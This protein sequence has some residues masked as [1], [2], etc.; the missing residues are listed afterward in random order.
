MVKLGHEGMGHEKV[1]PGRP[2]RQRWVL[3]NV[4]YST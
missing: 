3:A 4:K 2:Y 1:L